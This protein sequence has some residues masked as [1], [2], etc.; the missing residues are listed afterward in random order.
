M[1]A[2]TLGTFNRYREKPEGSSYRLT[3]PANAWTIRE[4]R[5]AHS[6]AGKTPEGLLLRRHLVAVDVTVLPTATNGLTKPEKVTVNLTVTHS[7]GVPLTNGAAGTAF[8]A[9]SVNSALGEIAKVVYMS[10]FT[11]FSGLITPDSIKAGEI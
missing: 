5:F 3:T 6:N 11:T 9:A 8:E 2:L 1:Y 10:A 7:D 4:L